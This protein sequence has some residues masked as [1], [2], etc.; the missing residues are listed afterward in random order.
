MARVNIGTISGLESGACPVCGN[1]QIFWE[2]TP[3]EVDVLADDR[4]SWWPTGSFTW[5]PT[6]D[7]VLEC[8]SC[9]L[10][11]RSELLDRGELDEVE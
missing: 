10:Q 2:R 9:G 4:R 8:G 5:E 1:E 6:G 7:T 3:V 11:F